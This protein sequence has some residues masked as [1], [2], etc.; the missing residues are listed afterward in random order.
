MEL[1]CSF[2]ID[3]EKPIRHGMKI[4]FY[5]I[6]EKLVFYEIR[7]VEEDSISATAYIYAEHALIPEMLEDPLTDIRVA[8]A[9]AAQALEAILSGTRWQVRNSIET[10]QASARFWYIN[11]WE[12]IKQIRDNWQV[13]LDFSWAIDDTGIVESMVN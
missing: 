3:T 4:G 5:D 2:P 9:T 11:R 7:T 10:A 8:N 1:S 6:D 12:A 13:A